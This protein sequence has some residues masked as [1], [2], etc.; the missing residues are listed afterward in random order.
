MLYSL[1]RED[2][3]IHFNSNT[4]SL[5]KVIF[6]VWELNVA[7]QKLLENALGT[8][9]VEGEISNLSRPTSGHLYFSLKDQKAQIRCAL[10][11]QKNV[12]TQ[13]LRNGLLV[14]VQ[15]KA[16]IY[17][18]RGDFQLIV[19]K[20]EMAGDGLL[21][22]AYEALLKKLSAEGLFLEAYKKPLP[23]LPQKIGLITSPTGAAIRDILS[24]LKRRF[25]SI[26]I[27][28]YPT[29]VQGNEA[30]S[31]IVRALKTAN[32]HASADVLI[33]ARGGGS[34]EDLWP[35]NEEQVARAIFESQ[36]PIISGVGHEIDFTIADF[37]ADQRAPTPSVA[38]EMA[39]PLDSELLQRVNQLQNTLSQGIHHYLNYQAQK[40]D[41]LLKSLQHPAQRIRDQQ[42]R[43]ETLQKQL[44]QA[45]QL[46]TQQKHRQIAYLLQALDGVS[47]LSTLERGYAIVSNQNGMI[48]RS[49]KE[50]K[51]EQA[52][53]IRLKDGV[54]HLSTPSSLFKS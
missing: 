4:P 18:D 39:T 29:S 34:L 44:L 3:I 21:K 42:Q 48:V 52:L 38:A 28:L 1:F 23:F 2:L 50:I 33:L 17:P 10:F 37:V 36:I 46:F 6:S 51:A 9:C 26:P 15:A 54:V 20:V 14:Q 35:F 11:R 12:A 40:V 31:E 22:Q 16:S 8:V 45:I 5:A 32:A 53:N 24:V 30:A 7:S 49:V 25:A 13:A 43:L 19:E 27:I 41:W 47:P